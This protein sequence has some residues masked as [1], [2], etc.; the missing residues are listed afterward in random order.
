[1]HE[2]LDIVKPGLAPRSH[3]TVPTP[4]TEAGPLRI[5]ILI[6]RAV[7][8]LYTIRKL[9]LTFTT[10]AMA[11]LPS[12]T[13]LLS[14]PW[15]LVR[16]LFDVLTY[17]VPRARPAP[18]WSFV[19][20]VRVRI[21]R[22]VLLCWSVLHWGERL[23]L[24]PGRERERFVTIRPASTKL[25]QGPLKDAL[26]KPQLLGLTWTPSRPPPTVTADTIV[27]L[28]FHGGGYV[29]GD[30]RD[31]DTGFL[32]TTL[33]GSMGCAHVCTPQY[34]LSS[35]NNGRFPAQLQDA[36]TAYLH[37]L[38]ELRIPAKQIIMSGD[39]AGANLA[40]ALLRYISNHG[41]ELDIP[42][43]GAV[44]LWSPWVDIG[45]AL[46]QDVTRS[47]NYGTDYIN[48]EFG[49]WGATTVTGFGAIDPTGPY[50]SPLHHPFQ[51]DM[52]VFV[53]TGDREVLCL[54]GNEFS[55]R[56]REM[57]ANL[58]LMVSKGCPHDILLLGPLM[59]FIKEGREAAAKAKA[60]LLRE[61]TMRLR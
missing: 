60:F 10:H 36:L 13:Y 39:S 47:P 43:P 9:T 19:K 31:H 16:F 49:R 11:I 12:I 3:L 15:E 8:V 22:S 37:L 17:I 1:M 25:Y 20:A 56:F 27:A 33:S 51:L 40:L 41:K 59:G 45:G 18:E 61:T 2:C 35:G 5:R 50:L 32:A 46:V 48:G 54:D 53:H 57:G 42:A 21:I 23:S 34:R 28:H 30:G 55:E 24:K 6:T 14:T 29:I 58:E 7:L 26:I 38:K 4:D 52:P 44:T